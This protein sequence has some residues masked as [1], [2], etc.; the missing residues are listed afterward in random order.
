MPDAV[1]V[2]LLDE[3]IVVGAVKSPADVMVP[4]EAVHVTEVCPDAANCWVAPSAT[5]AV[6]GETLIGPPS[7]CVSV[8]VAE[9]DWLLVPEAVIVTVPDEGIVAGA[10]KSPAD[11]MVPAEAVHVT[12][13][14]PD[15]LNFCVAPK[16][17]DA[18]SGE[19]VIGPP[20]FPETKVALMLLEYIDPGFL[21]WNTT[22]PGV[23]WYPL[24][25]N[26]VAVSDVMLI[27]FGPAS[28]WAPGWK[29]LPVT[30]T[31]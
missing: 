14:C 13:L 1:I 9:P 3:G 11:V 31:V 18:V 8:T 23:L 24:A 21:A 20:A 30:V 4:A 25:T 27:S 2:T 15:A 16:A 19:T 28:N 12:E 17:T 6:D 7:G 10:V 22:A 29:P 5:D 26:C